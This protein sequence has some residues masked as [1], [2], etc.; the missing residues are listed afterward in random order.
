MIPFVLR[1]FSLTQK[2][3]LV[4]SW[5]APHWL[6]VAGYTQSDVKQ[7]LTGHQQHDKETE[8]ST[9]TIDEGDNYTQHDHSPPFPL[10][11]DQIDSRV[12]DFIDSIDKG[13]VR[14]LASQHNGQKPCSITKHM[15]GSF[16]VCFFALFDDGTM[17]IVRIP[18]EPVV[19]D[20]WIKVQSEV[21]TM[22]FV[23]MILVSLADA[24]C[25]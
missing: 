13:A 10:V 20:S 24:E 9:A 25:L 23:H 4:L 17:W 6:L 8:D 19:Q 3:S 7:S 21:A 18:S 22:R 12:E 15:S 2:A 11:S 5:S 14:L 16:N 1:P